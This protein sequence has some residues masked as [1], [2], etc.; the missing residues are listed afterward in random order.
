MS[1]DIL[2]Y[3]TFFLLLQN[4][5]YNYDFSKNHNTELYTAEM[6]ITQDK[7]KI[8]KIMLP[9]LKVPTQTMASMNYYDSNMKN[10]T[11]YFKW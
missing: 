1:V 8:S 10:L 3:Y 9:T 4:L 2:I 6:F 7:K 11:D 5:K